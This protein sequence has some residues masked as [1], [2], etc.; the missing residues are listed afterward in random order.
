MSA[1]IDCYRTIA[2]MDFHHQTD[3]AAACFLGGS[4]DQ[5]RRHDLRGLGSISLIY[6]SNKSAGVF[7]I[8]S[9]AQFNGC[10]LDW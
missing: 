2:P 4:R 8:E 7:V 1:S 9:L 10:L 3:F 6:L 5:C